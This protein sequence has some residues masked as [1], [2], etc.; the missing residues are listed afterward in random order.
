MVIAVIAVPA[1]GCCCA[2]RGSRHCLIGVRVI[3]VFR[4]LVT[5]D[6]FPTN[7]PA[8]STCLDLLPEFCLTLQ[9]CFCSQST[10]VH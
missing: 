4:E 3:D 6:I 2:C 10:V 1:Q 7:L 5:A 9:L 8:L